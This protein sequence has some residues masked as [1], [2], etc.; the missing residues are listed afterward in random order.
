MKGIGLQIEARPAICLHFF[1]G[2]S[3]EQL[4]QVIRAAQAYIAANNQ[5][6]SQ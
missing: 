6:A 5:R 1:P 3:V 4:E 2:V